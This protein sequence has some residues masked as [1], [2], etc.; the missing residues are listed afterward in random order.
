M[1]LARLLDR[2]TSRLPRPVRYAVDW[3]LTIVLAAVGVLAFQAEIAKPYRIPTASMEPTLHCGAP[4]PGCR[5]RFA[6]RVIANRLAF[7][8]RDPHRGEIV[9]FRAP[10]AADLACG[11]GGAFVKRL[12]GLPGETIAI[13]DGHVLADGARL[14][15]SAYIHNR[16]QRGRQSGTWHVQP[17]HY[18]FLGDNRTASC[19]SRAWG[20]VPRRDLIGPVVATYWPPTRLG[21]R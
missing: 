4:A 16:L 13:Q 12:V 11:Q 8:F 5:A 19:D 15:E 14:E 1:P 2:S 21:L 18:F 17:G 20:S 6:D 7:R 10:P 9:V 3:V